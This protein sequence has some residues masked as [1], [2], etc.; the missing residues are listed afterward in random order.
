MLQAR[1]RVNISSKP[2]SVSVFSWGPGADFELH[3]VR[4]IG[5]LTSF[6]RQCIQEGTQRQRRLVE[7]RTSDVPTFAFSKSLIC[8]C[9]AEVALCLLFLITSLQS[10]S[11]DLQGVMSV[12]RPLNI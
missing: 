8:S 3:A 4:R 10:C 7:R 1:S 2:Q 9:E 5:K 6:A 12:I 11:T